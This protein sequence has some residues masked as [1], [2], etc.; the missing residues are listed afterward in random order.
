MNIQ[1]IIIEVEVY[2]S[3]TKFTN[4]FVVVVLNTGKRKGSMAG[5]RNVIFYIRLLQLSAV[6]LHLQSRIQSQLLNTS[7]KM[8]NHLYAFCTTHLRY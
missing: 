2:T 4:L 8:K 3:N 6:I 7:I 1:T 5:K